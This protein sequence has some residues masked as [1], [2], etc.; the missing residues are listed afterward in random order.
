MKETSLKLILMTMFH[1]RNPKTIT[2]IS[3][4][5]FIQGSIKATNNDDNEKEEEAQSPVATAEWIHH[6]WMIINPTG[7]ACLSL[8][9]N[10]HFPQ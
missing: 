1:L 3:L 8:I 10:Q 6:L 4:T 5:H 7:H 9:V 2:L